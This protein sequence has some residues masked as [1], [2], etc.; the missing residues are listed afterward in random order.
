MNEEMK[1]L[2]KNSTWVLVEPPKGKRVVGWEW[3][4]TSK[5]RA[6]KA[7]ERHKS[8]L[9]TQ[10]FSQSDG[11]DYSETF[12]TVAKLTSVRIL[13]AFAAHLI[14]RCVNLM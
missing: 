4:Y 6:D 1:A 5:Y 8:R 10:G 7:L 11:I 9:V 14:G 12:A 3:V 2:R 13:I